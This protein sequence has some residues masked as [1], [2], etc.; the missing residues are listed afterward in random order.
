M[1]CVRRGR[2]NRMTNPVHVTIY[3]H[4]GRVGKT[5]LTVNIAFALSSLGKKVLLVDSDPQS[6]LTSYLL[7]DDI[8]DDLLNHSNDRDGKTIWSAVRPVIQNTGSVRTVDP[9]RIEDDIALLPGDIRLFEFEEFLRK[10]WADGF[11]R[12]IPALQAISSINYLISS[13]N[14]QHDF[15]FVFYDTGPNIGDL[16]RLLLL[17]TDF[18]IVPLACDLFSIRALSTLGQ[19]IKK[20]IGEVEHINA[21]AP[22]DAVLL[23]GKPKFL[24]YIQQRF[25]MHGRKMTRQADSYHSRIRNR[26]YNDISS[27]LREVDSEL[28]PAYPK[29]PLIGNIQNFSPL[30]QAAQHEGVSFWNC[31]ASSNND[32]LKL[33]AKESFF[34]IDKHILHTAGDRRSFDFILN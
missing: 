2:S 15:D 10:A 7:A 8:V 29:N 28:A 31:T 6:N 1:R 5:A 30:A 11:K 25:H 21:I 27:V 20:W 16:N 17:G 3:S 9:T 22:D 19:T 32:H 13:L 4:K 18:F 24:G 12:R 14:R 23:E 34:Q 33:Q 26:V